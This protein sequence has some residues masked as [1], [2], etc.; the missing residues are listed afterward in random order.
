MRHLD[1]CVV[2]QQHVLALVAIAAVLCF[3]FGQTFDVLSCNRVCVLLMLIF[4]LLLSFVRI[5]FFSFDLHELKVTDGV[6]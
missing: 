4:P 5:F 1:L 6:V 2:L 3:T